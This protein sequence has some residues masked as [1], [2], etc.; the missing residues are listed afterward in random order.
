MILSTS[1]GVVA[2]AVF[3]TDGTQTLSSSRIKPGS[4]RSTET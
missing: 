3:V 4:A 1:S 2:A